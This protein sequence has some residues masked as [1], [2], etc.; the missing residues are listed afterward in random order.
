MGAVNGQRAATIL[1]GLALSCDPA[2]ADEPPASAEAAD[3]APSESADGDDATHTATA[4]GPRAQHRDDAADGGEDHASA[5]DLSLP[6]MRDPTVAANYETNQ[7]GTGYR[8]AQ[9][10]QFDAPIF[11]SPSAERR[12]VGLVRRNTRLAVDR[13]VPGEGCAKSWYALTEGGFVCS[14]E[15]FA[16][17]SD[18]APLTESLQVGVP[19]VDEP[20]PYRYA[21]LETPAPLYFRLPTE[22]ELSSGSGAPVREQA[23]GAHFVAMD[24]TLKVGETTLHR[25]VR[26]FYVRDEDLAH[27]PMPTM[28][29]ELLTGADALPLAFVHEAETS[30]LDPSSLEVQGTASQFSRFAIDEIVER[31]GQTLVV[32]ADGFAVPRDQVRVA[33]VHARPEEVPAGDKWIH[34]DLD[35]QVLVAYED[36]KPVLATLV[37]SGKEGFQPPLGL[38]RVHKKYTTVT[39]SGPDPDAGTYAV[40]QV[41]WTMYYWGSFALHGAY[42]HNSFGKVRSHGC[43]NIPP[44]DAR[45][46]FYWSDPGLP[47]GWHAKVGLKGPWLYFTSGDVTEAKPSGPAPTGRA[48]AP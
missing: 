7:A 20:L 47:T 18:P 37:S 28:H 31:D 25:T 23:Q 2:A 34:L 15:G 41:P 35:Q 38:F 36:D 44:I 21:K 48:V 45:F 1:V 40:E 12:V 46:L 24:Q 3:A 43:T 26:G 30:L 11:R 9:A 6:P 32:S 16:V 8:I 22:A 13:W 42:W 39:M 10:F 5:Q 19:T 4:K 17:S 27:K 33:K 29:G 14:G